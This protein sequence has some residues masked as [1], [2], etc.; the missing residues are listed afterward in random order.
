MRNMLW[1]ELV[2]TVVSVLLPSSSA[3][4]PKLLKGHW[5]EG[6]ESPDPEASESSAH[7]TLLTHDIVQNS[8]RLASVS[9]PWV[10][11]FI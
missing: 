10:C 6:T 5:S 3:T 8:S 11:F 9:Y 4:L 2:S 1:K 7:V